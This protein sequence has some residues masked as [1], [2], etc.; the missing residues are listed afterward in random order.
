M[1]AAFLRACLPDYLSAT[2]LFSEIRGVRVIRRSGGQQINRAQR[3]QKLR[4]ED[5]RSR[6]V[7]CYS[8]TK[9]ECNERDSTDG[10]A[11]ECERGIA[12]DYD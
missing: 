3:Q 8:L 2:L 6:I 12:R 9:E 7:L 11:V 5:S 10:R 1:F 4:N